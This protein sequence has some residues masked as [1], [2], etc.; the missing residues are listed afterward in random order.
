MKA[1]YYILA[2]GHTL[3]YIESVICTQW[4]FCCFS[5]FL[6]LCLYRKLSTYS[7][8]RCSPKYPITHKWEM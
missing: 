7:S 6:R 3:A 8:S 5:G 1:G 2:G 4:E